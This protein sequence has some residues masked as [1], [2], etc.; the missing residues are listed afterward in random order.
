DHFRPY[1]RHMLFCAL[2]ITILG[3]SFPVTRLLLGYPVLAGQA[4]RYAL[5]AVIL[6]ALVRGGTRPTGRQVARLVALAATGL[7][8]F[9]ICALAALRA[10][11]PP[12]LGT[13]VGATPLVLAIL[14]PAMARRRP[15]VRLAGAAAV[16]VT[17][18]ALVEG[19]GH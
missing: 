3:S 16:V 19:G 8:G 7:V 1:G 14:G 4:L 6:S 13:V 12:L 15:S 10:G 5:A 18:V 11:D 2:A 9:N 17:G